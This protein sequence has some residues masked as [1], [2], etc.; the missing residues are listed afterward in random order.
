MVKKNKQMQKIKRHFVFAGNNAIAALLFENNSWRQSS[1]HCWLLLLLLL[2]II[3]F[4]SHQ[5]CL[6][7]QQHN[8]SLSYVVLTIHG[9]CYF[10]FNNKMVTFTEF[11]PKKQL[12]LTP[13]LTLW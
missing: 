9:H 2:P 13:N 11:L 6:A 10:Q 12:L 4:Q 1:C 8:P 5:L 3:H 7:W